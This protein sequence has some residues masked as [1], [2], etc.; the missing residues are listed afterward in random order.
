MSFYRAA[1]TSPTPARKAFD[2][3]ADFGNVAQWDPG[4]VAATPLDG[5]VV[6][7]GS[8]FAVTARFAGR[9]VPLTYRVIEYEAQGQGPY[10]IRLL[11]ETADFVSDDTIL[12]SSAGAGC[13]VVYDA[14]LRFKGVRRLFDPIAQRIFNVIGKRAEQGL[15][16]ELARLG[17][18]V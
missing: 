6:K 8:R 11:A 5:L 9:N 4:V 17:S 15:G 2:Y 13:Q 14:E 10:K 3:L 16:T 7:V 12:V 1:L 18:G